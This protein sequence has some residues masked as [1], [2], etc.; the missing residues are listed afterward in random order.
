MP[1][2]SDSSA[3]G[4]AR[5]P[6]AILYVW[7][8]ITSQALCRYVWNKLSPPQHRQREEGDWCSALERAVHTIMGARCTELNFALSSLFVDPGRP[9]RFLPWGLFGVL[10]P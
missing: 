6:L 1:D 8:L 3:D 4:V 9:P 10:C 5:A 2:H 7:P